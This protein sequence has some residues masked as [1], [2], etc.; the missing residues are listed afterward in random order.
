MITVASALVVSACAPSVIKDGQP[1]N[2]GRV[3]PSAE[4][5]SVAPV[6]SLAAPVASSAAPVASS[7]AP[8]ASSAVSASPAP[9]PAAQVRREI[10]E[11][12]RADPIAQKAALELYERRGDIVGLEPEQVMNGG[13]R[14]MLHLVPEPPILAQRKHLE[15]VATALYDYDVFMSGLEASASGSSGAPLRYRVRPIA[16][17]FFRSLKA[18]SP[19]AF[20]YDWTVA[21]NLAGSLNKSA[22]AV[23]ET[24]FHEMFHLN[25]KAHKDWSSSALGALYA[26][27]TARCGTKIQCLTPYAPSETVIRGGTYYAFHPENGVPE[28]AAEL[29]LRYYREQRAMI[30]HKPLKKRPFKCGPEENA[31]AWRLLSGEFFAGVDL[32][33]PCAS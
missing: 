24:M 16:L 2:E 28:Y 7:A 22:D 17:R 18:R 12:L 13:Y 27:I 29:A 15:W 6:A 25:D 11:L 4:R 32:V 5:S 14:G 10:E 30:L 33:P 23:R 21:Y 19:T 3:A 26:D 20:A 31:R 1:S 9:A 8:V